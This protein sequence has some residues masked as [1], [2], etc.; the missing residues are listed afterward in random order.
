MILC[1]TILVSTGLGIHS[2]DLTGGHD[3]ADLTSYSDLIEPTATSIR[4]L[5]TVQWVHFISHVNNLNHYNSALFSICGDGKFSHH[6]LVS[7]N[8]H[9]MNNDKRISQHSQATVMCEQYST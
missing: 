2:L 3:P 8:F 1:R 4:T 9:C 5:L 7:I 6:M